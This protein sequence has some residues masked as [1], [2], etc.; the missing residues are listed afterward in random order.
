[1]Q[2]PSS[3]YIRGHVYAQ[4][5]ASQYYGPPAA[6]AAGLPPPAVIPAAMVIDAPQQPH[7]GVPACL[8]GQQ[9]QQHHQQQQQQHQQHQQQQPH[10]HQQHQPQKQQLQQVIPMVIDNDAGRGGSGSGGGSGGG[11]GINWVSPSMKSFQRL[12]VPETSDQKAV[13]F[14]RDFIDRINPPRGEGKR[15]PGDPSVLIALVL[16]RFTSFSH[17]LH[18]API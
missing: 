3:G 18:W 9:Q 16:V 6:A 10:Q 5:Q 1:M 7:I 4:T 2:Q 11:G 15:Q 13:Q 12:P 8:S 17:L 14:A